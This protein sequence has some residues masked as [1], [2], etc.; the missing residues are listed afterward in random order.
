MYPAVQCDMSQP[1]EYRR[2]R[3]KRRCEQSLTVTK[4]YL[5]TKSNSCHILEKTCTTYGCELLRKELVK[6]STSKSLLT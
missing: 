3:F 1:S 4:F 6:A 2:C 5:E